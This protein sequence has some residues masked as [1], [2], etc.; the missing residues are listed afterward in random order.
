MRCISLC[1]LGLALGAFLGLA[2]AFD[3]HNAFAQQVPYKASGTD[4]QYSPFTGYYEGTGTGTHVG[5]HSFFGSV[6][7]PLVPLPLPEDEPDVFFRAAFTGSQ[8]IVAANGDILAGDFDGEVKLRFFNPLVPEEFA[9]GRWEADLDIDPDSSTGRFAK[10]SGTL[11][12]VADNPP[13]N[14]FIDPVYPFDWTVKGK[15]DL[16]KRK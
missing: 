12:L 8:I 3:A 7:L 13:F 6:D 9:T 10:A 1:R 15:F 16:G 14:P 11:T 5:K 4:A 2:T